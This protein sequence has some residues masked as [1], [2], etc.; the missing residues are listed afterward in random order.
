MKSKWRNILDLVSFLTI[1]HILIGLRSFASPI[2]HQESL[3]LSRYWIQDRFIRT[4][5]L[6]STDAERLQA[7]ETL[8]RLAEQVKMIQPEVH[9]V[10]SLDEL[11]NYRNQILS[12]EVSTAEEI[13]HF[14]NGQL[15]TRTVIASD[16]Q[17]VNSKIKEINSAYSE[18]MDQK[19]SFPP[20]G[21]STSLL[22]LVG[23]LKK[24][25]TTLFDLIFE[26]SNDS[27]LAIN[28]IRKLPIEKKNEYLR[29]FNDQI[30]E[31]FLK[32]RSSG[33][34]IVNQFPIEIKD[35]RAKRF[36]EIILIEYFNQL[37]DDSIWNM[38]FLQMERPE[39]NSLMDRFLL[40]SQ[41]AGPQFHKLFQV[42]ASSVPN[43]PLE[44]ISV[45]KTFENSLPSGN[46]KLTSELIS[47]AK[48]DEFDILRP[49][50]EPPKV[51]SMKEIHF[52][53]VQFKHNGERGYVALPVPKPGIEKKLNED[54]AFL[55]KLADLIKMDPL[56]SKAGEGLDYGK[57]I[58]DLKE[59][60]NEELDSEQTFLNHK[61]A[62]SMLITKE[63]SILSSGK[64][65]NIV[66]PQVFK[67][68]NTKIIASKRVYGQTLRDFYADDPLVAREIAEI[69]FKNWLDKAIFRN[70]FIHADL[71]PGN[72]LI[73]KSISGNAFDAHLIDYG[74]AGILDENSRHLFM[75]LALGTSTKNSRIVARA[76]WEQSK[77]RNREITFDDFESGLKNVFEKADSL[78][79]NKLIEKSVEYASK[80]GF[81]FD[82]NFI[83][84]IRGYATARGLL[85][86]T[87]SEKKPKDLVIE[88][89]KHNPGLSL[90]SL[91]SA[92]Y[93][94]MDDYGQIA[95]QLGLNLKD[96]ITSRPDLVIEGGQKALSFGKS[97]F[98][99]AKTIGQT[100][101]ETASKS[102]VGKSVTSTLKGLWNTLITKPSVLTFDTCRS[103]YEK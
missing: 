8:L 31:L 25:E 17:T 69:I 62:M 51:A 16:S 44:L 53:E 97:L 63:S 11:D 67:S 59:L 73:E 79:E 28:A 61:N 88:L 20:K 9:Y 37:S 14:K 81:S 78:E 34:S 101:I 58:Q 27:K 33:A 92:K 26:N 23:Y 2:V 85:V 57:L 94:R 32:I 43:I 100:G 42:I 39:L 71:H 91:Q 15:T 30:S 5:S 21:F 47:Q 13:T 82:G 1:T 99:S 19:F 103:H 3:D 83:K 86:L 29:A 75:L 87:E 4:V 64:Q 6:A 41:N 60:V 76:L 22:T 102:E 56:L 49:T 77:S 54:N 74:M 10:K 35:P 68:T 45:F 48:F 65:I 95:K 55:D 40:V 84:L 70:G 7:L 66:V 89:F 18:I 24:R 46:K 96:L 52:A 50:E 12:P 98:Y 93:L 72:I 80:A 36:V 38:I 90:S